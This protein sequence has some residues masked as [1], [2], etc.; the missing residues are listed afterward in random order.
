MENLMN[1][2]TSGHI[3]VK[4]SKM[5]GAIEKG[6]SP[7]GG[8]NTVLW[9]PPVFRTVGRS[10]DTTF[11][12]PYQL[13]VCPNCTVLWFC[14]SNRKVQCCSGYLVCLFACFFVPYRSS[15]H[16]KTMAIYFGLDKSNTCLIFGLIFGF[17][18]VNLHLLQDRNNAARV[19][20]LDLEH[21]I[22]SVEK[23]WFIGHAGKY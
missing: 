8:L 23:Q 18:P 12:G 11:E 9:F 15:C 7:I 20:I 10:C 4:K 14:Y 2:K 5:V 19:R 16:Q 22:W 3:I 21:A 6:K 1:V 17:F 13:A